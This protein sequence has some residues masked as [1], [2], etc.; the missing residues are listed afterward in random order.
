MKPPNSP[1]Q[2]D[3]LHRAG[4]KRRILFTVDV[5]DYYMSPES[6]PISDWGKPEYPD[7]LEVGM[8]RL[9]DLLAKYEIQST[10]FW[11]GWLAE[12]HA[13]LVLRCLEEGHEIGTHTYDHRPVDSLTREEFRES[14]G[15]S[16]DILSNITGERVRSH[17]APMWSLSRDVDWMWEELVEAGIEVDSSIYPIESYLFGDSSAPRHPYIIETSSGSLLEVP[18]GTV[19]WLGKRMAL[20]GG[21]YLRA[22]PYLYL[23]ASLRNWDNERKPEPPEL[24]ETA[25]YQ[26]EPVVYIHPWELDPDHPDLPLEGKEKRVHWIGVKTTHS[27]LERLFRNSASLSFRRAFGLL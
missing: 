25:E 22:L 18:P 11:V 8:N 10:F 21:G 17:R 9:L 3:R 16:C 23:V 1:I 27:K 26:G 19:T 24:P 4:Q 6:I 13:D 12:R 2:P 14:L 7:R 20:G 5:E 15:K